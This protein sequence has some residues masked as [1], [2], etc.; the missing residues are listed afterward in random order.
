MAGD[1]GEIAAGD[2]GVEEVEEPVLFDGTTDGAA[3]LV[4]ALIGTEG[5]IAIAGVEVLI[6]KEPEGG[7]VDAV[8]AGL[9]DGVDDAAGGTAEFGGA[10]GDDLEFLNGVLGDV[11]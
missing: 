3:E 4:A 11:G 2:F 7:T 6:A 10:T 5:S 8:A 9:G 1:Q